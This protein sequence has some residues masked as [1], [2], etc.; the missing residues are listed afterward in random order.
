MGSPQIHLTPI[1]TGPSNMIHFHQ[2]SRVCT[3]GSL[4]MTKRQRTSCASHQSL[5]HE[6]QTKY[7]PWYIQPCAFSRDTTDFPPGLLRCARLSLSLSPTPPLFPGQG[8]GG[9]MLEAKKHNKLGDGWRGCVGGGKS[10]EKVNK[11]RS[12][13]FERTGSHHHSRTH[14]HTRRC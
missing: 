2:L 10:H 13:W 14:T 6:S 12:S 9:R 11:T 4:R 1:Y 5:W 7:V 8:E 3:P